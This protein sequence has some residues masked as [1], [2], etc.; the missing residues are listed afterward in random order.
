MIFF[1]GKHYNNDVDVVVVVTVDGV[2]RSVKTHFFFVKKE[3]EKKRVPFLLLLLLFGGARLALCRA[4][5]KW[6]EKRYTT[7]SPAAA[8]L[9]YSTFSSSNSVLSCR[10]SARAARFRKLTFDIQS[11]LN[12]RFVRSLRRPTIEKE[13]RE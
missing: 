5:S 3:E 7:F 10:P 2:G 13:R 6:R 12:S 1:F 11:Q 8:S 9:L 4:Q